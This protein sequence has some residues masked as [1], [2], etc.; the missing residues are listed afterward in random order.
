MNT[1]RARDA[2]YNWLYCIIGYGI[3]MLIL[4]KNFKNSYVIIILSV[5]G[6]GVIY[7]FLKAMVAFKKKNQALQTFN[8]SNIEDDEYLNQT[9]QLNHEI[10]QYAVSI[11]CL[12]EYYDELKMIKDEQA[13]VA[14]WKSLFYKYVEAING[15]YDNCATL[16]DFI[17]YYYN[18][19]RRVVEEK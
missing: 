14:K 2:I 9:I 8:E 10:S 6:A 4:S 3:L 1:K 17:D 11:I 5:L 19:E 7:M 13:L 18:W 16:E 15:E 12:S